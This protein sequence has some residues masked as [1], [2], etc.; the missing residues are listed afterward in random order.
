MAK[1]IKVGGGKPKREEGAPFSIN[2]T[3]QGHI[4]QAH[5]ARD[6]PDVLA[7]REAVGTGPLIAITDGASR[8]GMHTAR[9]PDG[10]ALT[11]AHG[12]SQTAGVRSEQVVGEGG[13]RGQLPALALTA[14]AGILDQA[15]RAIWR[16]PLHRQAFAAMQRHH[17]V[18]AIAEGAD[19]PHLIA[20]IVAAGLVDHLAIACPGV[21]NIQ[22]ASGHW[23][24]KPVKRAAQVGETPLLVCIPMTA[25]LDQLNIFALPHRDIHAQ[26]AED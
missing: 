12:K 8:V 21:V 19:I 23:R 17:L 25:I 13:G 16:F 5:Q 15:R 9:S 4:R 1:L 22:A 18:A 24:G 3:D 10:Q 6:I 11:Q 14:G 2:P 7:T 20:G 26:V